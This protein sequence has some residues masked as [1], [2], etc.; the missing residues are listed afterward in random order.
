MRVPKPVLPTQ[1]EDAIPL[2][3]VLSLKDRDGVLLD[4]YRF[5]NG[6]IAGWDL[7]KSEYK[8]CTFSGCRFTGA[9]MSKG[10]IRDVI[11][12]RC[13]LSGVRLVESSL[14]RV[15][16]LGCKLS[17][18][19][20]AGAVLQDVRFHECTADGI[21]LAESGLKN[22]QFENCKLQ[23][24]SFSSVRKKLSLSLDR[25]DLRAA[26]FFHTPL[27]SIDLTSC[28]IDGIRLEGPE[29]RGAIVTAIQ[30]CELAK[31]LG[32]VIRS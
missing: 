6:N 10:W 24:A 22:V 12:E 26:D 11:F 25:C 32:V 30:A 9:H 17:G 3:E 28:E 21:V 29:L 4:G 18:A 14:Q 23:Q 19:N 15:W 27:K 20:L 1:L 16:F 7:E 31:L 2:E 5:E 13:D 8:G